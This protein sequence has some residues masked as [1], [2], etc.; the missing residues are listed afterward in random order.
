MTNRLWID[1]RA[2]TEAEDASRWYEDRSP[3]AGIRLR[4]EV[5]A[6]FDRITEHSNLYEAIGGS[7]R[8]AF[9]RHFPF[10]VVYRVTPREVQVIGILPTRTDPLANTILLASRLA[11]LRDGD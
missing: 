9:T 11:D 6:V 1:P 10:A 2:L 7:F 5:D 4:H 8:R 3:G